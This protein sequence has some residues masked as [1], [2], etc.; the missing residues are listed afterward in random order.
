MEVPSSKHILH[1]A[2]FVTVG[3]QAH[4]T[5]A[6]LSSVQSQVQGLTPTRVEWLR[7][8]PPNRT[9]WFMPVFLVLGIWK[10]DFH[11]IKGYRVRLCLK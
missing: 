11:K 1:I 5:L 6:L 3:S 8:N 9:K 4:R 7:A 10:Q 2:Q